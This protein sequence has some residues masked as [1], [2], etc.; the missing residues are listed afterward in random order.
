MA[1]ETAILP[2]AYREFLESERVSPRTREVL[3]ERLAGPAATDVLTSA[4]MSTL[5][6]LCARVVPQSM[7]LDLAG[8]I[9]ARL[10]TGK[11]DG[12]RYAVLGEDLEA[13]RAGLDA[14]AALGF[15][16][17][18]DEAKDAAIEALGAV[19]GSADA[20]WFEEVRGDATTA[21]ISHPAAYA[22][23]GYSGIGVGGAKT[24]HQGFV[25]IAMGEVEAWEPKPEGGQS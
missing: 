14:L 5:R 25:E 8:T 2:E 20:R 6:A 12:W 11:G 19:K 10:A 24:V 21:Y 4:Q 3:E 22:R 9:A 23:L 16:G 7:G 1:K 15:D 13:Y 17:M 18:S